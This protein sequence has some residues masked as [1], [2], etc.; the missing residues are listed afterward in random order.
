M[1]YRTEGL[2]SDK[3][4]SGIG[5]GNIDVGY[6]R[7]KYLMSRPPMI[8]DLGITISKFLRKLCE[9]VSYFRDK[10]IAKIEFREN[11]RKKATA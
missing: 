3:F 11:L 7:Q 10:Y 2:K 9:K 4:F 8:I 6:R 5:Q 1:R